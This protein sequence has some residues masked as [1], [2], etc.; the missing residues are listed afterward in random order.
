MQCPEC[1]YLSMRKECPVCSGMGIEWVEAKDYRPLAKKG[2]T[3][4]SWWVVTERL[5]NGMYEARPKHPEYRGL[6]IRVRDDLKPQQWRLY[7]KGKGRLSGTGD[8]PSI[9]DLKTITTGERR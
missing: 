9:D 3:P 6:A 7:W 4:P 1:G 8:L 2:D 5:E